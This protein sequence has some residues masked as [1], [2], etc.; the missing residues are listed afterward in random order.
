[1]DISYLSNDD[2]LGQIGDIHYAITQ[3]NIS[4]DILV[5]AGDNL[6]NFSLIPSFSHFKK[7]NAIVN[8]LYDTKDVE[9]IKQ[10]S[11][12]KVG[13]NGRIVFF[14]EKPK[15]PITTTASIGIYYVPKRLVNMFDEYITSGKDADKMGYFMEYAVEK[16]H[17]HGFSH[18]EKWFDIGRLEALE[19]ARRDFAQ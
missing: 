2:R 6:F 16:E 4:D 11:Q 14:E 5:I 19:E 3:G 17:V 15:N 10:L 1:M 9:T 18:E 12:V 8:V 13:K 7:S